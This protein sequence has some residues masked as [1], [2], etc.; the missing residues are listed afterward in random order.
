[1]HNPSDLSTKKYRFKYN[2]LH[3]TV[4]FSKEHTQNINIQV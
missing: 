2:S 4:W 1:M 3:E